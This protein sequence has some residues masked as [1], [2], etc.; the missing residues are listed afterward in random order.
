[1][2]K[3]D[4]PNIYRAVLENLSTGVY[5]VDEDRR[6]VFWN[7]GAERVA[8]FLRHEVL[9][10]FCRE[11][12][13]V[14]CDENNAVLCGV[15]CPLL[16]TMRDGRPREA[17]VYLRH[18]DGHRVPVRVRGVPIRDPNGV[19]I[20]AA[21]SF[22]ERAIA[23]DS[24]CGLIHLGDEVDVEEATG[25]PGQDRMSA[26]LSARVAQFAEHQ[27]QFGILRIRLDQLSEWKR[28]GGQ[29]LL[30][31]I[32]RAVGQTLRSLLPPADL[33]GRC[34][35]DELLAIVAN[36]TPG[37]LDKLGARLKR[38]V[39]CTAIKWWGDYL[40]IQVSLG[41]AAV[42]PGDTP[43]SI[44]QRAEEALEHSRTA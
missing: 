35:E 31:L 1:M 32:L 36:A 5:L 11:N 23:P 13:L 25:L 17:E 28:R 4:D 21:E 7:D 10:R 20:G 44:L 15:A 27:T 39:D 16:D 3:F 9:G 37:D 26:R 34:G 41:S 43:E 40:P 38:I 19:I 8:G 22:E 12:I 18:K 2:S 14:H 33:L 6:I 24:N 30:G 42:N 29:Q